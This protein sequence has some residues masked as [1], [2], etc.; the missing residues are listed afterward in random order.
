MP[1]WGEDALLLAADDPDETVWREATPVSGKLFLVGD[2]KQSIYRFRRADVAIY[3]R[4]KARLRSRGADLVHLFLKI[5][6]LNT[7]GPT[8]GEVGGVGDGCVREGLT[9]DSHGHPVDL[10]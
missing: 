8:N 2:P 10:F 9:D 3:E 1:G 7:E 5:A 6:L 4:T